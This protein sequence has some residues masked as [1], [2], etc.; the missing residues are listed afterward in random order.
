MIPGGVIGDPHLF[1][2]DGLAFTFNGH[3]EFILL[4][5]NNSEIQGR[6][7]PL[8]RDG[9]PLAATI[10]SAVAGRQKSPDSDLVEFRLND[11]RSDVGAFLINFGIQYTICVVN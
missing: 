11:N 5:N 1:S 3:G 8:L 4:K 6:A 9:V 7:V 10:L 2:M